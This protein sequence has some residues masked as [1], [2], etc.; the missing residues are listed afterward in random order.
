MSRIFKNENIKIWV[1]F[2]VTMLVGAISYSYLPEQIPIHFNAAGEV[3]NYGG[4]ISIFLAPG[5]ILAMVIMAEFFRNADPKKSSYDKFNK[6]YYMIFF[7][8]SLLMFVI[9]LYT[10]AVS[11]EMKVY[12]INAIMPVAVGLLFAIIG[13][14]MPKFKQNYF[15]GIKTSWTLADEEVWFK[16]HRLG[17]KIWFFGGLMMIISAFLPNPLKIIVFMIV[18]A[19]LVIVPIVYSYIIYKKKYQ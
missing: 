12:N 19:I 8:V 16:T 5:V 9:Q 15:S 4:R 2:V 6:Q 1:L 11:L 7:L 10:I 3:D 17:G 18:I 14:S 13:N